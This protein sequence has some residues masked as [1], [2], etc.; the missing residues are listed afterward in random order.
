[1]TSTLMRTML[2]ST[3]LWLPLVGKAA[4]VSVDD[5][6]IPAGTATVTIPLMISP[7]SETE[8]IGAMN[9][10]FAV[11][12]SED[13]I[14][15]LG[16]GTEFD[17]SIWSNGGDFVGV[18]RTPGM[19]QQLSAVAMLDPLQIRPE[20]TLI[21]YTLVPSSLPAGTY[22]L[23]PDFQVDGIGTNADVPLTFI[24]GTLNI[25]SLLSPAFVAVAEM[26]EPIESVIQATY[27]AAPPFSLAS[28]PEPSTL[29]L[30]ALC[31]SLGLLARRGSLLQTI[32]QV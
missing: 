6:T 4:V 5:V 2:V 20:G 32:N 28:V 18:A 15:I 25:E 3:L 19:H 23:D 27:H 13:S 22:D 21:A 29:V 24:D 17:G 30:V 16:S 31:G 14:P 1:M 7:S 26:N 11:G 8:M 12:Q 10:S 9:I